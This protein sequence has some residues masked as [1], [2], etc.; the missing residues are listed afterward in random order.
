[1]K[2]KK[3][4]EIVTA[5]DVDV[6]GDGYYDDVQPKEEEGAGPDGVDK[7]VVKRV[8]IIIGVTLVILLGL[9]FAIAATMR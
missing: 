2:A 6:N 4:K 8:G 5:P 1:M 7:E 3:K 9:A